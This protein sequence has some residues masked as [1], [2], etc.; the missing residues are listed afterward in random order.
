M[1]SFTMDAPVNDVSIILCEMFEGEWGIGIWRQRSS[2]SDLSWL[3]Q[4]LNLWWNDIH[5]MLNQHTGRH[6]RD[7]IIVGFTTTYAIIVYHHKN[8]EFESRS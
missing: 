3:E 8:C 2:L 6:G 5:F 7:H 1:F 4:V